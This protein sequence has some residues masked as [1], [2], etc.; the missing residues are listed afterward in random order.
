M[1]PATNMT[2]EMDTPGPDSQR[3]DRGLQLFLPACRGMSICERTHTYTDTQRHH[4]HT[5]CH[6]HRYAHRDTP[7]MTH[8]HTTHVDTRTHIS[9]LSRWLPPHARPTPHPALVAE[10]P[11]AT[12]RR[13]Q[14]QVGA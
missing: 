12:T 9:L 7:S 3:A 5:P 11:F 4:T 14:L 13:R 2:L 6:T 1:K 8:R 10:C